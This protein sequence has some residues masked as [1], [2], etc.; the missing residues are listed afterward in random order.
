VTTAMPLLYDLTTVFSRSQNIK[1]AEGYNPDRLY[2]DQL[3]V[4][5]AF[6]AATQFPAGVDVFWGSMKDITTFKEFLDMLDPKEV[7]FIVDR[8]LFSQDLIKDFS[9]EGINYVVPLRK[10]SQPINLR[11]LRRQEAFICRNR[12]VRWARR[13]FV[14]S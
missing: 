10:N 14:F 12:A 6:S 13:P 4:I 8:G 11:W 1:R 5:L 3:G 2:V 7:V 9:D